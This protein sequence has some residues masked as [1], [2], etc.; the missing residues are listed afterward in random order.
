MAS[1]TDTMC[2][3]GGNFLGNPYSLVVNH[4]AGRVGVGTSNP[5]YKL[6]VAGTVNGSS[7]C[8]AGDCRPA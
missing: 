8:I 7:L 5:V 6:D 3:F 4:V 1:C 2:S